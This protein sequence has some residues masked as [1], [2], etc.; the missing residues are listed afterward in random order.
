MV[1]LSLLDLTAAFDTVDHDVLLQRLEK[2]FGFSGSLLQW[3]RSYLGNRCQS[4]Y[5]NGKTNVACPIICG[6]PQGSAMRLLLF[7]TIYSWHRR[8]YSIIWTSSSCVCWWQSGLCIL[9]IIG[10]RGLKEKTAR[11]HWLNPTMDGI[12]SSNAK[13]SKVW[14]YLVRLTA[15]GSPDRQIRLCIKGWNGHCVNRRQ[16]SWRF[17]M[18]PC[19]WLI[20]LIGWSDPVFINC[21]E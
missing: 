4:V 7:Y 21:M 15:M 1:L 20:T 14:I 6:V 18:N 5:L 13:P 19:Q 11:V 12:Q 9:F 8:Y 16:K 2:T 3:I 10:C 17:F